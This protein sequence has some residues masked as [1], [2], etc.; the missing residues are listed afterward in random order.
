MASVILNIAII[1]S[2]QVC[3]FQ[4]VYYITILYYFHIV[5]WILV[6]GEGAKINSN[7]A[8][9]LLSFLSLI[10]APKWGSSKLDAQLD[11]KQ[12]ILITQVTVDVKNT[13]KRWE[14]PNVPP[15][16]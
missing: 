10:L 8:S 2:F 13:G 7:F 4:K 3:M 6:E 14:T 11:L 15:F 16:L 5:I 1:Y 12:S 9:S